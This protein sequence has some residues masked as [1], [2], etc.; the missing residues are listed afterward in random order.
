MKTRMMWLA[1]LVMLVVPMSLQAESLY[2]SSKQ[3]FLFDKAA[4]NGKRLATLKQGDMVTV[5]AANGDWYQVKAGNPQVTGWINKLFVAKTQTVQRQDLSVGVSDLSTVATRTR[6]SA[7]TTSSAATRGLST[8][9]PRERENLAFS[10]YDFT[11]APWL[12]TFIFD[13][14]EIL[15]FAQNEGLAP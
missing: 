2:V 15:A 7:Y 4:A 1:L 9:N 5:V 8:D 14:S 6:A 10:S 11:V 12:D 13:E 3:A